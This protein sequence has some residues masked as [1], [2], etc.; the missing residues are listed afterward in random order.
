MVKKNEIIEVLIEYMSP[1]E[2]EEHLKNK[3]MF[4]KA[5]EDIDSRARVDAIYKTNLF[6]Y[7]KIKLRQFNMNWTATKVK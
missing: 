2:I 3:E 1:I 4:K 7:I 6:E 5:I